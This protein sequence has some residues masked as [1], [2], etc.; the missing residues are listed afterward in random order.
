MGEAWGRDK[1]KFCNFRRYNKIALAAVINRPFVNVVLSGAACVDHL[2]S[3]LQ[4]LKIK[5]NDSIELLADEIRTVGVQHRRS[6]NNVGPDG[7]LGRGAQLPGTQHD[8]RPDEG[9]RPRLLLSLQ[10]PCAGDRRADGSRARRLPG[11]YGL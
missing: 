10:L 4:A 5:W 1:L 6:E 3:N 7:T 11:P 2:K 8:A 9:R